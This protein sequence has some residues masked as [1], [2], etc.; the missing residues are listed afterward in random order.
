MIDP[1]ALLGVPR[2]LWL[3]DAEIDRVLRKASQ[4][5]HP[6]AGGNQEEFQKIRLAGELLKSPAKRV[7]AAIACEGLGFDERGAIP[8][9][10]MDYFSPVASVLQDVDGFVAD[11]SK[12]LSG[13]GKAV[14]DA[15]VPV[16]KVELER[17]IAQLS[18]LE[19]RM[20]S[21]FVDFDEKGWAQCSDEMSGVA[22]GLVFVTKWTAQL[23]E[24]S[25]K[26]FEAL[27]GE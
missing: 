27:L 11:R 21:R 1:F 26:L 7:R 19:S 23:R 18:E 25:G 14:L 15:R 2:K 4:L 5:H 17:V 13:L 9:E 22:R 10:V 3:D 20:V 6:D 16:L 24:A 8:S 12:A